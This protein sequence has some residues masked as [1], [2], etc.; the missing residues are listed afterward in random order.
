MVSVNRDIMIR[1]FC[2]L[3]GFVLFAR[4]GAGFGAVILAANGILMTVFHVGA[5]FLDGMATASEQLAGRVPLPAS[6]DQGRANCR[7]FA[8]LFRKNRLFLT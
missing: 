6:A 1:S 2:L 5:Y 4:L 8:K 3:T 7:G